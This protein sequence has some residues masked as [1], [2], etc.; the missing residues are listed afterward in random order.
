MA[1]TT[2][3]SWMTER[4]NSG[5]ADIKFRSIDGIEFDLHRALLQ[6]HAGAFPGP[7]IDTQ[8][9]IVQLT[10]PATVLQVLFDF[11]YPKRHS[12]L[13]DKDFE[14]MAA[15]AE[16]VEKYEVY[17]L[18]PLCNARLRTFLPRH[19][20]NILIHAVKHDYPKIIN[21]VL[22]YLPRSS[23]V[24]ILERLP[25]C[26]ML[27]WARY[28]EA[29]ARVFKL[30]RRYINELASEAVIMAPS[31]K[32]SKRRV[33]LCDCRSPTGASPSCVCCFCYISLSKWI[34]QL[35]EIDTISALNHALKSPK[36]NLDCCNSNSHRQSA[37][38]SHGWGG[39]QE[40]RTLGWTLQPEFE[41]ECKHMENI[42]KFLQ[43]QVKGIPPFVDFLVGK[44]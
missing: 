26:Y 9:E 34:T 4:F 1:T 12:D 14:F 15:L 18:M 3:P 16:A 10:E 22:P 19:A 13:E 17:S 7:E 8:G 41:V 6:A 31:P 5:N 24:S 2:D 36:S 35:D 29:W 33:S 38:S 32:S 27:A 11:I 37:E 44:K 42:S 40:P 23:F 43:D 28:V 25:P 21:E 20:E 30:G 39:E